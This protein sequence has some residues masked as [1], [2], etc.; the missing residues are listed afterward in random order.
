MC[1]LNMRAVAPIRFPALTDMALT[2]ANADGPLTI[3][4]ELNA[5]AQGGALVAAP[6]PNGA[7]ITQADGP[8]T[9]LGAAVLGEIVNGV[10][11]I[12]IQ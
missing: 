4:V 3:A 12:S 2:I 1:V 8:L 6:L 5:E 10:F 7:T 11:V 9:I